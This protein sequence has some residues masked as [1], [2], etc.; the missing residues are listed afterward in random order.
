MGD[1]W[2]VASGEFVRQ[3]NFASFDKVSDEVSD[4]EGL[5]RSFATTNH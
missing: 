2:R 3:S 1:E 5:T 4:K